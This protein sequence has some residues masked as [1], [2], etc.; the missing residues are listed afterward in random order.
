M[1]RVS[2]TKMSPEGGEQADLRRSPTRRMPSSS[3]IGQTPTV[4][5]RK[6]HAVPRPE[7]P[8]RQSHDPTEIAE[9]GPSTGYAFPWAGD[10]GNSPSATTVSSSPADQRRFSGRTPSSGARDV[11]QPTSTAQHRISVTARPRRPS[12]LL[13]E[14][15]P[16]SRRLSA[17]QMLLLTP[18]GVSYPPAR[19]TSPASPCLESQAAWETRRWTARPPGYRLSAWH[20]NQARWAEFDIILGPIRRWARLRYRN[21]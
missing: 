11:P 19:W 10:H 2:P 13:H 21:L 9:S 7:S 12:P 6:I 1:P 20:P 18:F 14:I 5:P 17:H 8:L 3:A 15:D 4:S 16:P